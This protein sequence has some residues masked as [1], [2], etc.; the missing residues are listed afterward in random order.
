MIFN[1]GQIFDKNI[2]YYSP[3]ETAKIALHVHPHDSL[4]VNLFPRRICDRL[5]SKTTSSCIKLT[6]SICPI[7]LPQRTSSCVIVLPPSK[8]SSLPWGPSRNQH[9]Q[10]PSSWYTGLDQLYRGSWQTQQVIS[11]KFNRQPG[12]ILIWNNTIWKESQM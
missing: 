8:F 11:E 7:K 2:C 4:D 3:F 1:S 6:S 10:N 12:A 9:C 5:V